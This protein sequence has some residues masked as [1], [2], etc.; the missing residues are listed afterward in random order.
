VEVALLSSLSLWSALLEHEGGNIS[1]PVALVSFVYLHVSRD[2]QR[3]IVISIYCCS[4]SSILWRLTQNSNGEP[5]TGYVI[6]P[7]IMIPDSNQCECILRYSQVTCS[8]HHFDSASQPPA[9]PS[10]PSIF[11]PSSLPAASLSHPPL[12]HA[13][14]P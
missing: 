5:A 7:S 14:N 4:Q 6:Y 10:A 1:F 12:P 9:S 3:T 11:P 2:F 13:S 8:H